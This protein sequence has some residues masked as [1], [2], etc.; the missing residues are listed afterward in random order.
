[1]NIAKSN[2]KF[3]KYFLGD[4]NIDDKSS[5]NFTFTRQ[6]RFWD[7]KYG[8]FSIFAFFFYGNEFQ[9]GTPD[10]K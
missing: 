1:M 10:N 6:I 7:P 2:K 8:S 5:P 4:V 9:L 3:L